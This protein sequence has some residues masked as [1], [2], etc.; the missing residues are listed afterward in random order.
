M[1]QSTNFQCAKALPLDNA[2]NCHHMQDRS[3]ERPE[4]LS[5]GRRL[6][7]SGKELKDEQNYS[8]A[9]FKSRTKNTLTCRPG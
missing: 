3:M 7:A 1:S 9:F 6:L 8:L 2:A 5:V 4:D